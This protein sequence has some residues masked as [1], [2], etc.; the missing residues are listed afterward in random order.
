MCLNWNICILPAICLPA[1]C[2]PSTSISCQEK[3]T[4]ICIHHAGI[5]FVF[6]IVNPCHQ[7][8][9]VVHYRIWHVTSFSLNFPNS[10][11]THTHTQSI[12]HEPLTVQFPRMPWAPCP[13]DGWV[14][15]LVPSS[16]LHHGHC[17][18]HT[19]QTRVGRSWVTGWGT[20]VLQ[21][22][23]SPWGNNV[24]QKMIHQLLANNTWTVSYI[25]FLL[26]Q[27]CHAKFSQ[28]TALKTSWQKIQ[29]VTSNLVGNLDWNTQS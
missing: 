3:H 27:F 1:V 18:E 15:R 25:S 21:L 4:R 11:H 2:R 22:S 16:D 9:T 6:Q 7:K 19:G 8:Y 20:A 28:E 26:L 13:P 10:A 12:H 5:F 24:Q 29:Q 14:W 23:L 17:T